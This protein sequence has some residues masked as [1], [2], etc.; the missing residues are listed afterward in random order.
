[1]NWVDLKYRQEPD[2]CMR[3]GSPDPAKWRCGWWWFAYARM[4]NDHDLQGN[5][6]EVITENPQFSFILADLHPHVLALPFA[7]L[8]V[9]L[10]YNLALRKRR[11]YPW[12]FLLYAI[13]TGG[14]IFLNSWDAVYLGLIIGAEGLR[15]LMNNGT[16][17]SRLKIGAGS[18]SSA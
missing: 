10:A 18:R 12:E 13:F 16:G 1:M 2:D 9:G 14:M 3:S 4:I 8:V 6:I 15:R 17:N 5:P 11:L 7:V